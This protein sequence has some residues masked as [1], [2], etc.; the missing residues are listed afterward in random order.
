MCVLLTTASLTQ[1]LTCCK[2][3]IN[4]CWVLVYTHT[5]KKGYNITCNLCHPHSSWKDPPDFQGDFLGLGG[6]GASSND[7]APGYQTPTRASIWPPTLRSMF[8]YN[9]L[10]RETRQQLSQLQHHT[11]TLG[12]L[13]KSAALSH[14]PGKGTNSFRKP[15]KLFCPGAV[16]GQRTVT[17]KKGHRVTIYG[18]PVLC[19]ACHWL[20]YLHY[21]IR[22]QGCHPH[23]RNE[24]AEPSESQGI[25]PKVV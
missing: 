13:Q 17:R 1:W 16:I 15:P 14:Y 25:L 18:A 3:P 6:Q 19:Q 11:W 10:L 22:N 7:S 12:S 23:I 20:F 8:V 24:K 21:L 9:Y 5:H 4:I 2:S